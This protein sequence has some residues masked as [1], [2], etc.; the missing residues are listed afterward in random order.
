MK[1]GI[2]FEL[3][4][5]MKFIRRVTKVSTWLLIREDL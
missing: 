2:L 1:S 4:Y 5:M 3:N